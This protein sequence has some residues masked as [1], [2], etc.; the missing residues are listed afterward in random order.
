MGDLILRDSATGES[1]TFS[2]SSYGYAEAEQ[3]RTNHESQGHIVTDDSSGSLGRLDY[4]YPNHSYG[5]F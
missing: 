1:K 4:L 3:W 5:G 2:A